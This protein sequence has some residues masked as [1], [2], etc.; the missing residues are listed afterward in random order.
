MTLSFSKNMIKEKIWLK[1]IKI[2]TRI[3]GIFR[4]VSVEIYKHYFIIIMLKPKM[5]Y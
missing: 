3:E 4:E 2:R 1:C 5:N